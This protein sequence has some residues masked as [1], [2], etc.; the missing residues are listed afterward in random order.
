VVFDAVALVVSDQGVALLA[1]KPPARDFIADAFAHL[2][3]VGYVEAAKPLLRKAGVLDSLDEG[4]ITLSG[5]AD[6]AAF[7]AACGALRLW[8]REPGITPV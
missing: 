7:V 3:F 8:D 6:A 4:F 2:K 5:P 1:N